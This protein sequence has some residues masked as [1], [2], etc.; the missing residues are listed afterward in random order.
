M[1]NRCQRQTGIELQTARNVDFDRWLN[2]DFRPFHIISQRLRNQLTGIG[3][4]GFG[5]TDIGFDVPTWRVHREGGANAKSTA[6]VNLARLQY[7]NSVMVERFI[8][9]V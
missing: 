9:A 6:R 2:N 3:C 1:I 4:Q 8:T 7:R 5:I